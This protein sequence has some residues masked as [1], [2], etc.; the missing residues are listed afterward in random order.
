MYNLSFLIDILDK[1]HIFVIVAQPTLSTLYQTK[2]LI[3]KCMGSRDYES[4][5]WILN[6]RWL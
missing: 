6:A 2:M 3:L 5:C 4:K 1:I